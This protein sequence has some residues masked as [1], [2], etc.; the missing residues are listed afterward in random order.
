MSTTVRTRPARRE[1]G[2]LSKMQAPLTRPTS[3]AG[4]NTG[5][6]SQIPGTSSN[7]KPG[8]YLAAISARRKYGTARKIREPG[9][10]RCEMG[11]PRRSAPGGCTP[12]HR[13][14]CDLV[15]RAPHPPHEGNAARPQQI[16]VHLVFRFLRDS[17]DSLYGTVRVPVGLL[18]TSVCLGTYGLVGRLVAAPRVTITIEDRFGP[19]VSN[20][21]L[22]V[23]HLDCKPGVEA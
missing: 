2:G 13:V 4:T 3:S 7:E 22:L 23:S 19:S 18:C 10:R 9:R 17:S 1:L 12:L 20:R 8:G 15:E 21:R 11:L 6:P 14:R 16:G 5:K